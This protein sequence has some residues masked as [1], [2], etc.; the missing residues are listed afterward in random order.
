ME[1]KEIITDK[2]YCTV[3]EVYI[4]VDPN[5][6]ALSTQG[7]HYAG[8]VCFGKILLLFYKKD[9]ESFFNYFT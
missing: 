4:S 5:K 1:A 7:S 6:N 2:K 8:H 9:T 3:L